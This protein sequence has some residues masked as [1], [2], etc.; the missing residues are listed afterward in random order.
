MITFN[1]VLEQGAIC[2]LETIGEAVLNFE[3]HALMA[4]DELCEAIHMIHEEYR[5]R[6]D[7]PI[8]PEIVERMKSEVDKYFTAQ[9]EK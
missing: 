4:P 7:G 1:D 2:G 6:G 3:M 9:G 8:P 5:K